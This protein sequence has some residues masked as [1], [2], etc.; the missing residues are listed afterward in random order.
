MKFTPLGDEKRFTKERINTT[1]VILFMLALPIF[2]LSVFFKW[3]AMITFF[4][5]CMV[6]G[7]L[8]F[9]VYKVYSYIKNKL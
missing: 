7:S 2:I 5:F 8:T 4:A 9:I 6:L 3:E 1:L